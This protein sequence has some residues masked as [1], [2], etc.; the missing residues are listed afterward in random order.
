MTLSDHVTRKY[1]ASLTETVTA[2][3][4]VITGTDHDQDA[5]P[6]MVIRHS[7]IEEAER[8]A[9]LMEQS[10]YE[11]TNIKSILDITND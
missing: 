5:A 6:V 3:S 9:N 11:R 2:D 4:F 8:V 7:G 1:L 10:G